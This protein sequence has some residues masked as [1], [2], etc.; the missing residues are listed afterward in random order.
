MKTAIPSAILILV[1]GTLGVEA[2]SRFGSG[3]C[4]RSSCG[5]TLAPCGGSA[6]DL[7]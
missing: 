5:L 1:L 6:A 3:Y 7:Q 2:G 4:R